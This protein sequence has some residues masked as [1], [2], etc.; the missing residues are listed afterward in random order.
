[1]LLLD[2]L[3]FPQQLVLPQEFVVGDQVLHLAHWHGH[4]SLEKIS[5]VIGIRFCWSQNDILSWSRS[6]KNG[7]M[8]ILDLESKL[9]LTETGVSQ[10]FSVELLLSKNDEVS[11]PRLLRP[12]KSL[13]AFFKAL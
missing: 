6:L 1:M 2:F 7:N 10:R 4:R 5:W 9:I 12:L 13:V 11:P 3:V 8:D